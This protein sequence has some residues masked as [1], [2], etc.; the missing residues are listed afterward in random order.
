MEKRISPVT[1]QAEYHLPMKDRILL[2]LASNGVFISITIITMV[3]MVLSLNLRGFIDP[4]HKLFYSET[5]SGMAAPGGIF[6][7]KTGRGQIPNILHV[8]ITNGFDEMVYRPL[9]KKLA[10]FE[11]HRSTKGYENSII[12]KYFIYEFLITFADLFYIAFVRLDIEGLREQLFSLFFIDIIR[13]LVAESLLPWVKKTLRSRSLKKNYE[14]ETLSYEEELEKGAI[15]EADKEPYEQFDDY[16]EIIT[17]FGYLVMISSCFPLAPLL[18]LI[19]HEVEILQDKY[20][21]VHIFKRKL[22]QNYVG[23]GRWKNIIV[24]MCYISI[25]TVTLPSLR[26]SC[27]SP[28]ALNRSPVFSPSCSTGVRTLSMVTPT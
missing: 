16:L 25:I 27:C 6:D 23:M 12:I 24:F 19:A 28:S 3:F 5:L 18:I 15:L 21:I 17:N 22:P 7:A 1:G 13:R 4:Q 14:K 26:I 2:Q 8:V 10:K 9:A 20:K 11:R